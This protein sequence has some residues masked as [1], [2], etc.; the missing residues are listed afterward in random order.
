MNDAEITNASMT[1]DSPDVLTDLNTELRLLGTGARFL[2]G[3]T[4]DNPDGFD[5]QD[6]VERIGTDG[7]LLLTDVPS[8]DITHALQVDGDV[9]LDN[10]S[11]SAALGATLSGFAELRLDNASTVGIEGNLTSAGYI[12][13][14]SS[15]GFS[16]SSLSVDG[17][18]TNSGFVN[19][20]N[21]G[22][23]SPSVVMSSGLDNTGTIALS[24]GPS[25]KAMLHV[26]GATSG[27]G[28]IQLYDRAEVELDGA[29]AAGQTITFGGTND[30]LKLGAPASF[31]GDIAGFASG[32]IIDLEGETIVGMGYAAS[33]LTA[34]LLAGGPRTLN[35]TGPFT[36]LSATTDGGGTNIA[37]VGASVN[38]TAG[39]DVLLF[40]S[41]NHT[42]KGTVAT[43]SAV[44]NLM[45][46]S[47][48][49]TLSLAGGGVFDLG[50]LAGFSGFEKV[51]LD[52][53]GS[54][55]TLRAGVGLTVNGGSAKDTITG[56]SG[57]D[58]I[59]G[60]AGDDVM[61]GGAGSDTFF[62][63]SAGDKVSESKDGGTADLVAARASYALDTGSEIEFLRTTSNAGTTA[64]NLT[65]NALKQ[66][67]TGNAGANILNEGGA[68]G[69][70]KLSGLGGDD[71][72][73]IHNS[74]AVI[75]ET[76]TQGT[77]D[78]LMTSVNYKLGA[79]VHI[80]QMTTN[81][82]SGTTGINLIGNEIVQ[83]IIGNAGTNIIDGKGGSDTLQGGSG[84][85]YFTFSTALGAANVDTIV[86]FNV[87]ADTIRLENA[88]F[89][90]LTVAGALASAHFRANAAG[91]AQDSDD[92]IIYET[93]T[94][95][96]FYDTDGNGATAAIQFAT[97]AGNPTLTAA[98]FVV[99]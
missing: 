1:I 4:T 42:A 23:G 36:G 35:L 43:L 84:K 33:T 11:L 73:R 69:G 9:V 31:K 94:G 86:D 89:T 91:T 70:D 18:F 85:D 66:E 52:N 53:T 82:S 13:L 67:I 25:G 48:I 50:A 8:F 95:K 97:L 7:A 5:I 47:G 45:G 88:V 59:D 46:G 10:S 24:G 60:G 57:N 54:T 81:G 20:G 62:V 3:V 16:G 98:D 29:V 76:A 19:V 93:D 6:T 27:G 55:L 79:G 40:L 32:D 64:I 38:L 96:L 17:L 56:N 80:E 15:S 77:A 39:R 2:T 72:Y 14:D 12:Q 65:G 71:T 51:T 44:D 75:V 28:E 90:T 58:T 68:G 99:I 37:T 41:G 30:V 26:T 22:L 34:T 63:D 83:K 87:A 61:A 74:A 21:D 49:D 78:K 92:N